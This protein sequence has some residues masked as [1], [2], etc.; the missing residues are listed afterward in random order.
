MSAA[1]PRRGEVWWV[2][3]GLSSDQARDTTKRLRPYLVI[4]SD[5]FNL[6][7]TYPRVTLCPLTGRERVP[8]EYQTDVLLRRRD[9][10]K[11]PKDSVIRCSEVYTVFRD[12]LVERVGTAPSHRMKQV[13]R[14]LFLYLALPG[15]DL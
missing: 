14:A 8:R 6:V 11:L 7:P 10:T 2:R 9:V 3:Q 12:A 15:R 13:D 5:S 4:S 1:V